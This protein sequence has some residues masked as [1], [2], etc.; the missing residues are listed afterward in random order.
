M[1][2]QTIY[3][4]KERWGGVEVNEAKRLRS[5]EDEN[6]RSRSWG[7]ARER[8]GGDDDDNMDATECIDRAV[9]GSG[10]AVCRS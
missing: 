7:F 9:D 3:R 1:T 4:W 5:L 8:L 2:Q 10:R 6:A